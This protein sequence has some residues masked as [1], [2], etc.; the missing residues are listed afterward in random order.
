MH[1]NPLSLHKWYLRNVGQLAKNVTDIPAVLVK[2]EGHRRL[3]L[4]II[5]KHNSWRLGKILL[6][7][8]VQIYNIQYYDQRNTQ[9]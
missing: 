5:A 8:Q 3:H 2:L 4:M 9:Q 7:V 1:F 6:E